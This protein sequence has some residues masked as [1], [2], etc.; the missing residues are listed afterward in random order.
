MPAA[1]AATI[2]VNSLG[3]TVVAAD[4]SCTLREAINNANSNSDTTSGDCV[5]G[6]GSDVIV[7][8]AGTISVTG[9][10]GNNDNSS[11]DFDITDTDDLTIQGQG[12]GISVIDGAGIDRVLHVTVNAQLTVENLTISGGTVT[13]SGGG[14]LSLGA[15]TVSNSAIT[16]NTAS[17]FG[18]G[19]AAS[20]TVILAE[21]LISNNSAANSGGGI[22]TF[23][24]ISLTNSTVSN[25]TSGNRG[26]G[27]TGVSG[28]SV[29]NSTVS[30]NSAD[31]LG[32]GINS[33][34]EVSLTRSTVSNNSAGARGGGINSLTTVSVTESTLSNNTAE[35]SGGG[36][37]SLG[38]T[39]LTN[40]TVNGNTSG[41]RG[42]GI[43]SFA[44]VDLINSSVSG[45]SADNTGG[46]ITSALGGSVN[47]ST[48]ILNHS[49]ALGG[50]I[51]S[52]NPL[53]LQNS[54]LAGNSASSDPDGSGPLNS[55][56]FNLVGD[57]S[58][59]TGSLGTG[60]DL[61]FTELGVAN[62]SEVLQTGLAGN[63]SLVLAGDPDTA[64][65]VRTHALIGNSPALSVI[66]AG[67]ASTDQRGIARPQP[68]T[69]TNCDIG[70]FESDLISVPPP[71]PTSQPSPSP[72]PETENPSTPPRPITPSEPP[73]VIVVHRI[74]NTDTY[75]DLPQDPND[76][77]P[78]WPGGPTS[79][80]QGSV[81][82]SIQ[83]GDPLE[84]A[85]Y[86]LNRGGGTARKVQLCGLVPAGFVLDPNTLEFDLNQFVSVTLDGEEIPDP[87]L[88]FF[89]AGSETPV[90]C[91]PAGTNRNGAIVLSI[92][93]LRSGSA[94]IVRYRF[95]RE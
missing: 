21:S 26:G 95:T 53:S 49:N 76:N 18:G 17:I 62:I 64:T 57:T 25:N 41:N 10:A 24:S 92:P 47:H 89:P 50:G 3:D 66:S 37:A 22:S 77:D 67:C 39:S 70:A 87:A 19:L 5:A 93:S 86:F 11:G 28:V 27:M 78:H 58:G 79:F 12:A 42:G 61:T 73:E 82:A 16:G 6:T 55:N 83:A 30:N 91:N 45:N 51:F 43:V 72:T 36:I 80:L 32:G 44:G 59:I 65:P 38:Q 29:I 14:I 4:S 63:G 33:L 23:G 75:T 88:E 81:Q 84:L 71:T 1:H 40:S 46:G 54:I 90:A 74:L 34:A 35:G 85:V 13:G 9:S 60:S 69:E 68:A 94:G 7:L 56:G 8:P 52:Y 48:V 20:D 15:I 31:E 2:S